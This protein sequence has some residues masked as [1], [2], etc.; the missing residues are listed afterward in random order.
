MLP[1]LK[2]WV[3]HN[4]AVGER[5]VRLLGIPSGFTLNGCR[6]AK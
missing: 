2:E 5:F 3:T 4:A 6:T 1:C